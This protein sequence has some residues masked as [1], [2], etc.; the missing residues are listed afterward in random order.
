MDS[1]LGRQ[2]IFNRNN[3]VIG[4]EILF[5]NSEQNRAE[6]NDSYDATLN[7]I[8]NIIIDFDI[9]K[10][11]SNKR[12]F[13]NFGKKALIDKVPELFSPEQLIIEVLDFIEIDKELINILKYY[14]NKGYIIALDDFIYQKNQKDLYDLID[15]IKID[16]L[17]YTIDEIKNIIE[18]MKKYNKIVLAEKIEDLIMF[19]E[20]KKLNINYYQGYFFQKP[21]V[22]KKEMIS[23]ISTIHNNL[24]KELNKEPVDYK[25]A[26]NIIKKDSNLTFSFLKLV[27][28]MA[29]YGNNRIDSIENA[30]IRL[31]ISESKKIILIHFIKNIESK[32]SSSELLKISLRRGKQSELL[33][34]HFDLKEDKNKLFILGLF[35]L[36]NIILRQSMNSILSS[37]ALNEEISD[38]LLGEKNRLSKVLEVII[39]IENGQINEINNI[40]D[41]YNISIKTINKIYLDSIDWVDS[42]W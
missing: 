7:V 14:K 36:I 22:L 41:K 3:E 18:K 13:I 34:K 21:V 38:A 37:I 26:A 12:S 25:Q 30:M 16:F 28:S 42:I 35:S 31:G 20:A 32:V 24:L 33:A 23:S 19:E 1:F 5:R 17:K 9:N 2:P 11:S 4:Y 39:L 8:K 27:N 10:I 6:F 40:I 29:Y 15:I